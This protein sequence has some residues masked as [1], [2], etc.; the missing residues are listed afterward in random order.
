MG[1]LSYPER[2]ITVSREREKEPPAGLDNH[3]QMLLDQR[4]MLK[5]AERAEK[6]K[7]VEERTILSLNAPSLLPAIASCHQSQAVGWARR[8]MRQRGHGSS[9]F[10]ET[11]D[12]QAAPHALAPGE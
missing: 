6:A 2:I 1:G 7:L 9:S 12:W 4:F 10:G 5:G 8:K 11:R 3:G